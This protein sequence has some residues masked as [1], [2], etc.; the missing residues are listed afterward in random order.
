MQIGIRHQCSLFPSE[1]QH[2]T[3]LWASLLQALRQHEKLVL[4]ADPVNGK[5]NFVHLER[6]GIDLQPFAAEG[7]LRVLTVH[8]TFLRQ[9]VFDPGRMISW[10]RNETR[11]ARSEGYRALRVAAEMTWVLLAPTG[12]ERLLDYERELNE[13]CS[14]A[15]CQVL[16]QYDGRRFSPAALRQVLAVHPTATVGAKV[17]H[18]SHY[19]IAPT[20]CG[21]GPVFTKLGQWLAD[22]PAHYQIAPTGCGKGPAFTK[23][24]QWLAD[25]PAHGQ[26]VLT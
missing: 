8:Q 25:L 13:V 22:L 9:G 16:C 21:K 5:T 6:L 20:G 15:D 24:G 19:Q 10:L 3:S 11:R 2:G 26:E 14:G 4:I 17:Y 1:E 12:S 18:N 23:L 7:Q